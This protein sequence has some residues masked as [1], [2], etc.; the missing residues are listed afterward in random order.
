MNVIL[1]IITTWTINGISLYQSQYIEKILKKYNYYDHK[2]VCTQFDPTVKLL[3]NEGRSVRQNEYASIIGSLR[4]ATD[5]TRPDIAY[6][7]GVLGRFTSCPG[8]KHWYAVE[9]VMR[10]LKRT[11]HLGLHY[12]KDPAVLEGYSDA[13]WNIFRTI[14]KPQVATFLTLLVVL[15]HGNP[16]KKVFWLNQLW[17]QNYLH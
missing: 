12:S 13:D 10:Y 14:L 6:A 4:Y 16:R 9:R 17:S 5:C 8:M 11:M 2:P 15:C 1:G 7:V 3:K